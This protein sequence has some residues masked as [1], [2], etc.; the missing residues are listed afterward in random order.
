MR[1]RLAVALLALLCLLLTGC[2]CKVILRGGLGVA[3]GNVEVEVD[4]T[5]AENAEKNERAAPAPDT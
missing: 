1:S 4:C 5:A 2:G 3:G